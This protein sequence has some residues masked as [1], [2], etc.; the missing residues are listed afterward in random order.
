MAFVTN[1]AADQPSKY[2]RALTQLDTST[3]AVTRSRLDEAHARIDRGDRPLMA[4]FDLI[5]GLTGFG[6]YHRGAIPTTTSLVCMA[7]ASLVM[8]RW[9]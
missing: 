5:R 2:G 7:S 9:V 1:A 8:P 3:T 6:V 4:E